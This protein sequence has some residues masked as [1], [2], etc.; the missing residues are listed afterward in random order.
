MLTELVGAMFH[1]EGL[2]ETVGTPEQKLAV[3]TVPIT[4]ERHR[5]YVLGAA[6]RIC[7]SLN[8]QA[9]DTSTTTADD[10]AA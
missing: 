3:H 7:R 10:T 8:Q 6:D 9:A 5:E 2:L 1:L 4:A